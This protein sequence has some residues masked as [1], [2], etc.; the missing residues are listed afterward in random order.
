MNLFGTNACSPLSTIC[1]L[2][3]WCCCRCFS[4]FVFISVS[5]LWSLSLRI[6]PAIT[7]VECVACDLQWEI[8]PRERER[9][10]CAGLLFSVVVLDFYDT[11]HG[12]LCDKRAANMP[13]KAGKLHAKFMKKKKKTKLQT[14]PRA[15]ISF[16]KFFAN[17]VLRN[18]Q[19]WSMNVFCMREKRE[20]CGRAIE[21]P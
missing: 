6:T 4:Y 17:I 3:C 14:Y 1:E 20:K 18:W 11:L 5:V 10:Y 9:C 16:R 15:C 7:S 13:V 8:E 19:L 12:V 21:Q 2:Y